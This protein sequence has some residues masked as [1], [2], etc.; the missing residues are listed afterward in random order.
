ME[1]IFNIVSRPK[2]KNETGY[3]LIQR[4]NIYS[5]K[6]HKVGHKTLNVDKLPFFNVELD[7]DLIE[8]LR[9]GNSYIIRQNIID[10][11]YK[12]WMDYNI[13]IPFQQAGN[14]LTIE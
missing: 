14:I 1:V 12:N 2:S 10:S 7:D 4:L 9:H 11:L 8:K 13:F 5:E 3:Y 6:N